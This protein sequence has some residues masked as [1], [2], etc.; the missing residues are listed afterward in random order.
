MNDQPRPMDFEPPEHSSSIEYRSL[1]EGYLA[2]CKVRDALAEQLKVNHTLELRTA[3]NTIGESGLK[4]RV[5]NL[6]R[7][8]AYAKN[9][10][11]ARDIYHEIE[12]LERGE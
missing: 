9:M 10:I 5:A 12:R 3:L 6:E 4:E 1:Y 2:V 11:G 8:L 7:A